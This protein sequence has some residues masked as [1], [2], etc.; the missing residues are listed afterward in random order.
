MVFPLSLGVLCQRERQENRKC[1]SIWLLAPGEAKPRA[2]DGGYQHFEHAQDDGRLLS[3]A[4]LV[5]RNTVGTKAR[6]RK[7]LAWY[8]PR[9]LFH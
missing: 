1:S 5:D 6:D 2:K 3:E 9:T 7:G 8:R 4:Y